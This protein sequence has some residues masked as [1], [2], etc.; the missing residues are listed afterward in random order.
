[1]TST[2]PLSLAA[3]V[4]SPWSHPARSL[5]AASLKSASAALARLAQRLAVPDPVADP[6]LAT[7]LEFYADAGAPEGA[8]YLNGQLVGWIPGVKRL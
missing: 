8:L 4:A 7:V 5:A 1:M 2:K 3:Q 6:P